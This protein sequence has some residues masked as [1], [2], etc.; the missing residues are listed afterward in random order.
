MIASY[1][2]HC[3]DLSNPA[4]PINQAKQWSVRLSQEFMNQVEAEQAHNIPIT[5]YMQG[6]ESVA[7]LYKS[8]VHFI[9]AFAKPL[10]TNLNTYF[11]GLF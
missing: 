3:A 9:K 11:D 8:E 5:K 1:I 10:W 2:V 4:K 7:M 6:L